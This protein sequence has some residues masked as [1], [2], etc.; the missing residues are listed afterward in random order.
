MS[1][2]GGRVAAHD[3][4]RWNVALISPR[5][6]TSRGNDLRSA[7]TIRGELARAGRHDE[8]AAESID[9]AIEQRQVGRAPH[10]GVE[11]GA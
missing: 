2:K 6:R 8:L 3:E 5:A 4:T 1:W 10:F 7:G 9:A 11:F